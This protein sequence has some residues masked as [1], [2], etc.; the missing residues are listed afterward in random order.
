MNIS[1]F[2]PRWGSEHLNWKDFLYR[3]KDVGFQG[4]EIG[5]P[6]SIGETEEMLQL[7]EEFE[8]QFILQHYETNS[9]E[10]LSHRKLYNDTLT[11]LASYHPYLINSHTGKDH[12]SI[13]QNSILLKDAD[14]IEQS[15]KVTITHETH[16]G[17]FSFSPFNVMNYIKDNPSLKLTLDISHWFCVTESLLE[18]FDDEL[19]LIS[20]QVE[21]LHARFG[22]TQGPQIEDIQDDIHNEVKARHFQI[23][24]SL[25]QY[26]KN[27]DCKNF[28]ITM[29]VG[30]WPYLRSR[31]SPS[32]NWDIQFKQ[33]CLLLHTFKNRYINL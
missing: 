21:H 24:D 5:L 33:N 10:F 12:F 20:Q 26:K 18:H 11:T 31:L 14:L 17:R 6:P 3:I 4:V 22:H 29:E 25:I 7:L 19:N 27:T 32:Q 2:Y 13:E 1:Y 15:S 23:W 16:R 9:H 28:P 30:P 8:L